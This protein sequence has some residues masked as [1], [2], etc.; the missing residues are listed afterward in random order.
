MAGTLAEEVRKRKVADALNG[1]DDEEDTSDVQNGEEDTS[2]VQ[3][4]E[5]ATGTLSDTGETD[6]LAEEE[7]I[8]QEAVSPVAEEK[9]PSLGYR[10][11]PVT[12]PTQDVPQNVP[13]GTY[14]T[15]AEDQTGAPTPQIYT[16]PA[17]EGGQRYVIDQDTGQKIP[18]AEPATAEDKAAQ[19]PLS[20][21]EL[22][23]IKV[24]GQAPVE[25]APDTLTQVERGELVKLPAEA[26]GQLTQVE[27]GELVSVPPGTAPRAVAVPS[28]LA[29]K[30][31]L[32]AA[33]ST[34]FAVTPT[35]PAVKPAEPA[36]PPVPTAEYTD[37]V[38]KWRAAMQAYGFDAK[39]KPDG[40]WVGVDSSGKEVTPEQNKGLYQFGARLSQQYGFSGQE[41]KLGQLGDAAPTAPAVKPAEVIPTPSK[42][43]PA[44]PVTTNPDG[45][46]FP[47]RVQA[48]GNNDPAAFIVHHTSGRGTVD[49][50][51]ST[52]KE[53]GLGVQ[54]V[55]D[56]DGNIYQTGGPG[57]QNILKGWG[58]GEG[59]SNQNIVGMEI[60]AK[61]D[62]DVTDAQKQSFARFIAARYPN[63]PL[64]GHGEV[65]PGHK[66]ADEGLSAKTAALAYRAQLSQGGAPAQVAGQPGAAPQAQPVTKQ[67]NGLYQNEK[68][69]DFLSGR[70]TTFATPEDIASGQDN[71]V[72][73][74]RLGKLD[75]TSVAGVA[76]PEEALRAKYGNNYAAWRRAR[77]DVV[78]P[79]TG[80]RLRVPIVDLGP[81][82]DM[83]AITDMT[84]TL[85]S[86]F[87]GDKNLMVKLVD[88][89]GPDVVKNPQLFADEQAAI[90]QGF[91]SSTLQPGVQKIAPK[92]GYSFK[93]VDPDRN[94]ALQQ[95]FEQA[96]KAAIAQLPEQ[97]Q[98]LPALINRLDQPIKGV[99]DAMRQNYQQVVKDQATKYAQD[100]YGIQDPKA[101]YAKMMSSPDVGTF[102]G[103]IKNK[104]LPYLNQAVTA[105]NQSA[106]TI[107]QNRLDMLAK[108][109]HPEATLEG[110]KAF[111][112]S[113]TSI[114]DEA[115]RASTINHLI[116][117]LDPNN[118]ALAALNPVD[119]A[120]SASRMANPEYQKRQQQEIARQ[121]D[122]NTKALRPDPRLQG[123]AAGWWAD[124]FAQLPKNVIEGI[125]G[126]LG[127]SL[128]L[129]EIYQGTVARLRQDNPGMSEDELKARAAGT[130]MAQIVPAE[131][132]N[133]LAGGKLGGVT[134]AIENPVQRIGLSALAHVGLG[135]PVGVVQ[136]AG[137]NVAE[138]K[139][140]TEG[141]LQ[142]AGAG[143]VQAL[144]G[145]AGALVHGAREPGVRPEGISP[146]PKDEAVQPPLVTPEKPQLTTRP[147]SAIDVL[148]PEP[149]Q[150]IAPEQ[151]DDVLKVV[152]HNVFPDL[153]DYEAKQVADRMAALTARNLETDRFRYE[154]ERFL[155]QGLPY[156]FGSTTRLMQAYGAFRDGPTVY[157]ALEL[158]RAQDAFNA[159]RNPQVRAPGALKLPIM[160]REV[161]A[162]IPAE[163][164]QPLPVTPQPL[165]VTPLPG[166]PRSIDPTTQAL[167]AGQPHIY[168][169]DPQ[170]REDVAMIIGSTDG[171]Y[172]VM[173]PRQGMG[174]TGVYA[175][176]EE[177]QAAARDAFQKSGWNL[178][179]RV[180]AP[181]VTPVTP[182]TQEDVARR[183]YE[184]GEERAKNGQ[185]GTTLD[186][187]KQAQQDLSQATEPPPVTQGESEPWVSA[188]AN[189]FTAERAAGGEIGEVIPGEGYSKEE[190]LARGLQMG[191]EEINQ[192]ISDLM[193][194][195]GD[196]KLQAAAVR[197][198]EARLSQRSNAA[199]RASE[200]NPANNQ[201]RTDANVAF[202]D[203]TDFHNGPVATLKNNWH[204]QGMTLQGEIP[205]D[206]STFNGLRERFLR[207]NGEAPP[208]NMEP[209]LRK[210]AK[211]VADS[212]AADRAAMDNLGKE[213]QRQSA[214]RRLPTDE[215]VRNRIAEAVKDYPCRT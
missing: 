200:A 21:K 207:E 140:I 194:N 62:K 51:V 117:T 213:I 23:Q 106:V 15:I 9:A 196:P 28:P 114:P 6:T 99:P 37:R 178:S 125:T 215:E 138:G 81:R 181:P 45:S 161:E 84:P 5:A 47:Q 143:A 75:T 27:R 46:D 169:T 100:Y 199:S 110:R 133:R 60:I 32:P 109:L 209:L 90:R 172:Q 189:R 183:T 30:P 48:V 165:P 29:V 102:F 95:G 63:T 148:G 128:M 168:A 36:V 130:T 155:P 14:P 204:A 136:Q 187:W 43:Q 66:E 142:A 24:Q 34:A 79:Q 54:F 123:T 105:F 1:Q 166:Q 98:S 58:K 186:D 104:V 112:N 121:V 4:G 182:V 174:A 55:M 137:I 151:A 2:D 86:Y 214:R 88:N 42:V 85:S 201:L 179:G 41:Q 192:H 190:L 208:K 64:Y 206:L 176:K 159:I 191:P 175:T 131:I 146:A 69:Q 202:Q 20:A 72:G 7:A 150:T 205:I 167:R 44:Q 16:G 212:T 56:R 13:G 94:T 26:P 197:A 80:K 33:P 163:P 193:H 53:R 25:P 96:S 124:Q 78:D 103:E 177:A 31:A 119:I 38:Q 171:T 129:S 83:T 76:I 126:P 97:N 73:A 39:V 149:P 67:A 184:L 50:V 118:P 160:W 89:A 11:V 92:L 195:T 77:V 68:P 122:A 10:F 52:L 108:A 49:G 132:L 203:L 170:G 12:P 116:G 180:E 127:Q 61:D 162:Q 101:A 17:E 57:A 211:A 188:I 154:L 141:L 156:S 3:N 91:D 93:P 158:Q 144:P 152:A 22:Q 70:A 107:D 157:T 153:N 135:A 198:E 210:T 113:I 74:P 8:D 18:Y 40:T 35:A 139:P 111:I 65:N 82:G 115:V 185:P 19:P 87:G 164:T 71:G 59:L 134:G 145:V 173:M 147:L 120:D